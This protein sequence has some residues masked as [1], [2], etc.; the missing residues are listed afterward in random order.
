LVFVER[1]LGSSKLKSIMR[2]IDSFTKSPRR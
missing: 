1:E 2:K